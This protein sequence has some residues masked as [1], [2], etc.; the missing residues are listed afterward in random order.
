MAE[1]KGITGGGGY[2]RGWDLAWATSPLPCWPVRG[3]PFR[4]PRRAG[5][6]SP[7]HAGEWD[8]GENVAEAIQKLGCHAPSV[9]ASACSKRP[10]RCNWPAS[11]GTPFEVCI[12]SNYQSGAVKQLQEPPTRPDAGRR[13]ECDHQHRRPKHLPD[14][15][16]R[17]VPCLLAKPLVFPWRSCA[18][19]SWLQRGSIPAR[20]RGGK[21]WPGVRERI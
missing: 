18:S 15:L 16:E 13:A 20:N 9:M 2:R 8:G 19:A 21:H 6:R 7:P 17:R 4:L 5:C 12:T 11:G 14:R 1:I 3:L 10:L